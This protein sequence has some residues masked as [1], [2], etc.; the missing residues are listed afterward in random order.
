MR[1]V[2]FLSLLMFLASCGQDGGGSS[3]TKSGGCNL[4][5]RAVACE[6]IRG[7]DG[8]GIDLL[9]SM[10]EV[11]VQISDSVIT[12]MADKAATSEGRRIS[13]PTSVRSGETYRYSL[14]DGGL[15]VATE[16]GS[17]QMKRTSS[18]EG[19]VGSWTWKG[20]I[21]QGTHVIRH[22]TILSSKVILRTSCEL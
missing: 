13:C 2:T 14:R 8:L 16:N 9:E 20:Y 17:Y 1:L 5:G 4:N 21:D 10:I 6:S 18:G 11:P 7:A 3:S 15:F 22:M 19:L 12:F